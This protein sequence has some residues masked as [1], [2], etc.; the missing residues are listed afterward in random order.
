MFSKSIYTGL[1]DLDQIIFIKMKPC[2]LQDE[3]K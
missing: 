2:F 1:L 3:G